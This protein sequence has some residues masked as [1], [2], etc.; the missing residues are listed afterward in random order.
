LSR[1]KGKKQFKK[2]EFSCFES[3]QEKK[4][5][6]KKK[7]SVVLN[8]VKGKNNI[9]RKRIQL[10]GIK[11][12]EKKRLLTDGWPLRR[13]AIMTAMSS[14]SSGMPDDTDDSPF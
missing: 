6:L 7:N 10:S 1:V 11:G 12:I 13:H 5:N 8:Q 9:L 2:K 3:S 4:N 14:S